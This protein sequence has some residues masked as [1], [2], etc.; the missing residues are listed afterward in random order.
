MVRGQVRSDIGPVDGGLHLVGNQ[1]QDHPAALDGFGD[2][3]DLEPVAP[4]L[5][6]ETVFDVADDHIE[7][8]IPHVLGLGVPLA[9]V[10]QDRDPA[11]LDQPEVGVLFGVETIPFQLAFRF[12]HCANLPEPNEIGAGRVVVIHDPF[13]ETDPH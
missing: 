11:I 1:H 9:A 13:Y 10:P 12:C 2:G 7:T 6:R 3:N 4:R 8:L 5:F